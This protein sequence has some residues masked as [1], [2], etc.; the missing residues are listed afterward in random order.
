MDT[1]DLLPLGNPDGV[2]DL[3]PS[4]IV[5][6][7][8]SYGSNHGQAFLAYAPDIL[9]AGMVAGAVRLI[10]LL[11]YQDR[12]TPTGDPPLIQQ[13]LP[14]FVTGIRAPDLWFALSLFAVTYDRQDPHNHARFLFR[15]P[16]SVGGT[17]RKPSLLVV[18][19]IDDS[20]TKN[21]STRSLAWQLGPIPQLAPAV[22]PLP[23]LPQRSG[24]IQANLDPQ[25]TA[26]MVQFA[27]TGAGVPPTPGCGSEGHFCAQT[28]PSARAQ[29]LNF[30]Q[31]SLVGPP[32]ID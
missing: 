23:D 11:E 25:T 5:Y 22:V 3:D 32:V 10:E 17:T 24:P 4:Q 20:F 28:A 19:G 15:E 30:Y 26:A 7:G 12:T 13:V 14:G 8:I 31:S 27:P 18:E 16:V 6:E 29:R 2:P 21:N 9:A 1:L